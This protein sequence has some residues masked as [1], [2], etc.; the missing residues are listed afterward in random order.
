MTTE[1]RGESA[2]LLPV[3]LWA[4]VIAFAF[5][6]SHGLLES[7]EG[8]YAEAA[9]EMMETGNWLIPQLDYH[10]H[11]TKPPVT[12]WAIAGGMKLFGVN[13]WGVR[14]CNALAFI[15]IV[16]AVA[17]LGTLLWDRRTGVAASLVYAVSP[18]VVYAASSIQTD[19]LLSLA[20]IL[21]VVCYF[22]ALKEPGAR[23]A[24]RWIILLWAAAAVAFLIKGP[25][26]LLTLFAL[27][28][29]QFYRRRKGLPVPRL[30]SLPGLLCFF[31]VGSSWFLVVIAK[32]PG[33]LSY[34][35]RDEV[36]GRILTAQSDRNP[37]WYKPFVVYLPVLLFGVGPIALLWPY[38]AKR[39][40][41][42]LKFAALK[43]LFA[44]ND[45]AAF[46]ILWLGIPVVIL[47][48]V[49]SRLP[50]YVLPFFP[51]LALATARA[52]FLACDSSKL[53][54]RLWTLAIVLG[55]ALI[56]AKAAIAYAPLKNDMR[57]LHAECMK[58]WGTDADYFVLNSHEQYGLQF[59]LKGRMTHLFWEE[60][61]PKGIEDAR[62]VLKRLRAKPEHPTWVFIDLSRKEGG[63]IGALLDEAGFKHEAQRT[64]AGFTAVIVKPTQGQ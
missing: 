56:G 52:M 29:Y 38:L 27:A 14:F 33:L 15:G 11:W 51:V 40:S 43:Q 36:A 53:M 49:K 22:E 46:L 59:Y 26:S 47:S 24:R 10:P 17:R 4:A 60:K 35:L 21:V 16:C 20:Q 9:R 31:V 1:T 34:Y 7:T 42:H 37:Q 44:T 23:A 39:Y 64:K 12:Y 61:L 8:R 25:P 30:L 48:L 19:V 62:D 41:Q 28:A 6:G 13:E 57:A 54:R 3:I 63:E 55:I 18:F 5:L 50:L 45:R 58:T 2:R 32:T